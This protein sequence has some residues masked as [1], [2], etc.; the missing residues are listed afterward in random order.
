M[1]IL[2]K[3]IPVDKYINTTPNT[4]ALITLSARITIL[5]ERLYDE[6]SVINIDIKPP[7]MIVK[8]E[9]S[10]PTRAVAASKSQQKNL[11]PEPLFIDCGDPNYV[12]KVAKIKE[13]VAKIKNN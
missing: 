7:N 5:L 9:D 1:Y 13:E 3:G 2:E 10:Q 4:K 12:L 11:D 6:M 8:I